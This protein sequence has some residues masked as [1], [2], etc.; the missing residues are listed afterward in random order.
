MS[1]ITR[2]TEPIVTELSKPITESI[3]TGVRSIAE[4]RENG[5]VVLTHNS[6]YDA[7]NP[8]PWEGSCQSPYNFVYCYKYFNSGNKRI[9]SAWFKWKFSGRVLWH[10]IIR[11]TYYF[12]LDN[13][14]NDVRLEA[15][16]LVRKNSSF[17]NP[18]I[19]T[20]KCGPQ[21]AHLDGM[22]DVTE[23]AIFTGTHTLYPIPASLTEWGTHADPFIGGRWGHWGLIVYSDNGFRI[24]ALPYLNVFETQF[25]VEGD[26][27]GNQAIMGFAYDMI[28]KFPEIYPTK[29]AGDSYI[30]D[31]TS[32]LTVH[33]CKFSM[34]L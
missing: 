31:T 13:D 34:G 16:D 15:M 24:T 26:T 1:N 12:I 4:S 28:L 32:A 6:P 7:G 8:D 9:Q 17:L 25:I 27:T 14:T 33:R 30:A 29:K 22:V 23:T 3:P 11:D 21:R 5:L 10:T 20:E 19:L 18:N 2:E